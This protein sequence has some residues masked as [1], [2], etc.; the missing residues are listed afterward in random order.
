MSQSSRTSAA[1]PSA[2]TNPSRSTSKGRL[3]PLEDSAV[4]L[5]NPA[6]AVGVNGASEPPASTA[7]QRPSAMR[8]AALP[9]AWVPAAHA[10]T[11]FSEGPIH[12]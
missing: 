10:V 7:S 12:P 4:M 3:T 5:A 6:T 2:I 11:T 1:A 9:T 8:R